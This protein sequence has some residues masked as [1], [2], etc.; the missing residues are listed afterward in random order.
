MVLYLLKRNRDLDFLVC[1]GDSNNSVNIM[2]I[3]CVRVMF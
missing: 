1:G 3:S 2:V